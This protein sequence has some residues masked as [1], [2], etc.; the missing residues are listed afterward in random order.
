MGRNLL[1]IGKVGTGF[2]DHD[3]AALIKTFSQLKTSMP[4]LQGLEHDDTIVWLEPVLVGE[5]AYQEVTRDRKLRI[6]RFIRIRSDKKPEECTTDQLADVNSR[7][8]F[9]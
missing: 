8:P 5:V 7:T 3:R 9:A 4:Q 6:P 1:S 2:S